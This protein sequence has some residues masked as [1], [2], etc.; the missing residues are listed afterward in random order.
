MGKGSGE[1]QAQEDQAQLSVGL[2]RGG[3]QERDGGLWGVLSA[4]A[5][6]SPRLLLIL[7]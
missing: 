5:P 6:P 2:R 3:A 1:R 7:L 4:D